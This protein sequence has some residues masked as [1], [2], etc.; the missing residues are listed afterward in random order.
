MLTDLLPLVPQ[1]GFD[2]LRYILLGGGPIAKSVL[3]KCQ[4]KQL[5]VIQSYGMTETCSQVV[6][7]PPEKLLK[8]R[9]LWGSP[10]RCSFTNC[11]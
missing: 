10:A 7:L 9:R 2:S 11:D 6:A 3:E 1:Q 5:S 8:N 4:Q